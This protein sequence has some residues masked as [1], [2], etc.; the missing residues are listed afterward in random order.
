[1]SS[2]SWPIKKWWQCLS[3]YVVRINQGNIGMLKTNTAS[4]DTVN[5]SIISQLQYHFLNDAILIKRMTQ[6]ELS[7]TKSNLTIWNINFKRNIKST[8]VRNIEI[9][10]VLPV[11]QCLKV[12]F[13]HILLRVLVKQSSAYSCSVIKGQRTPTYQFYPAFHKAPSSSCRLLLLP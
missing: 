9:I 10:Q 11:A 12:V 1:M 6:W 4:C 3:Y 7:F 13:S 2:V 8:D 5:C